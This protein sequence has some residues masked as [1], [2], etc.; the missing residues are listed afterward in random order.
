M[1]DSCN[2]TSLLES[3]V[4]G[5]AVPEVEGF[6]AACGGDAVVLLLDVPVLRAKRA[7]VTVINSAK[8]LQNHVI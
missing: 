7:L 5:L 4:G 2:L 6:A 8:S 3:R 1:V